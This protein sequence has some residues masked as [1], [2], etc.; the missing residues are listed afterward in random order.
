MQVVDLHTDT[1]HKLAGISVQSG[2]PCVT[3][4]A[5]DNG[6]VKHIC[7]AFF[8]GVN[9]EAEVQ[10]L[11]VQRQM[12]VF[13]SLGNKIGS[14][15]PHAAI[16][17]LDFATPEVLTCLIN[18]CSPVYATLTWNH[19]AGICGSCIEDFP[20]TNWGKGMVRL[21]EANGV[22]PD[23]SHAGQ[24][25]FFSVFD[26]AEA[27]IV[28]HSCASAITPHRRNLTDEQIR[29]MIRRNSL[30]G[31]NFYS[32]FCGG[33]IQ[34]L[35]RHVLHI[36]DLGGEDILAIGS[37]FDGCSSLPE[38]LASPSDFPMLYQSLE[39]HNVPIYIIEKI[40]HKNA[41]DKLGF[42]YQNK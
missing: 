31:I 38:G 36:L 28:T 19:T 27:P 39:K 13:K 8:C 17:G 1:L 42:N 12:E 26:N 35:V 29:L 40:F 25:A 34:S 14:C 9:P 11:N 2:D 4:E 18:D 15:T 7:F 23:L 20:L 33:T 24:K 30:L 22:R 32:D 21:L 3:A 6:N 10:R 37:D 41:C 5:L 16:E